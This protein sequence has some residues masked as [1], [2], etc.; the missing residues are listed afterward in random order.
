MEFIRN[1][2]GT[3]FFAALV[4]VVGALTGPSMWRWINAKLP[5]SK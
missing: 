2:L 3:G 5:W 4:F 1:A